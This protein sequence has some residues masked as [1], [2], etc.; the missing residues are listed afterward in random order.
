[1]LRRGLRRIGDRL[2][3]SDLS[4]EIGFLIVE[5][6]IVRAIG[7]KPEGE[8]HRREEKQDS[9]QHCYTGDR[10]VLPYFPV[11]NDG[12]STS[13]PGNYSAR[14]NSGT[15]DSLNDCNQFITG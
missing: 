5:L 8:K 14:N 15:G 11:S 7:V 9:G 4:N 12:A 2:E 3:L 6:F 13:A 10:V 1:M